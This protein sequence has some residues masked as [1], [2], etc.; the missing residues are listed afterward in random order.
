MNNA[1]NGYAP[2]DPNMSGISSRAN[3]AV[4]DGR[5]RIIR[6]QVGLLDLPQGWTRQYANSSLCITNKKRTL[7]LKI[8]L[9]AEVYID[10]RL[11]KEEFKSEKFPFE[12]VADA[13]TKMKQL[14]LENTGMLIAV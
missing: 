7:F 12:S 6:E 9:N 8:T 13:A 4:V 2:A 1:N 10:R 5:W 3:R 11:S 14:V